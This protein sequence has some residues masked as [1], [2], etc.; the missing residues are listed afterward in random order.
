M[1][2]PPKAVDEIAVRSRGVPRIANRLLKRV[3][4]V[5]DSPTPKQTAR[6]MAELGVDSWGMDEG[7][8]TILMLL[9]RRFQGGP[10]GVRTLAAAAGHEERTLVEAFEPYI[11]RRGLI[12]VT[13]RGRQLT[14]KGYFYCQQVAERW[15][16]FDDLAN[17]RIASR[18]RS[19][20]QRADNNGY[21]PFG[22]I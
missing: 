21:R 1:Q 9:Y 12:D 8:R 10:V 16:K 17:A 6:I 14:V 7:D 18:G 13:E 11:V 19:V 2:L 3:R 15:P 4:D 22:Q 20:K 5:T